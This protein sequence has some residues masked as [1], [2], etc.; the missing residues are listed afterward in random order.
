LS[1]CTLPKRLE[2]ESILAYTI[3][4]S[5]ICAKIK[6]LEKRKQRAQFFTPLKVSKFMGDMFTIDKT[7][8]KL[9]DAGA[10]VGNLSAAF[11]QRLLDSREKY[12]IKID[13]YENDQEL[14]P[15]LANNLKVCIQ[16]LNDNGHQASYNILAHD[17]VEKNQAFLDSNMV[18]QPSLDIGYD[19][20]ISNPPYY[21]LN[22]ESIQAEIMRNHKLG[23]PNIYALFMILAAR[24]LKQNGELVF[25]TPRSFCSGLYFNKFRKIFLETVRIDHIH[26]FQSRRDIFRDDDV[27]QENILLRATKSNVAL[28]TVKISSSK[29]KQFSDYGEIVAAKT[30]V[31]FKK[32]GDVFIRIP[33]SQCD[34][35]IQRL[36][37]AFPNVLHD[38]GLEVSTGPVVIFRT[39]ETVNSQ[40]DSECTTVPLLWAHNLNNMLIDLSRE[41]KGK[42]K[43][44]KVNE[45]SRSILVQRKNYILTKRFSSKE[46]QKRLQTAVFAKDSFPHKFVAFENHLNFIHQLKGEMPDEVMWGLAA[47]LSSNIVDNFFKSL[48][49]STQVNAVEIRSLPL[50]SMEQIKEIGTKIMQ[51]KPVTDYLI[52]NIVLST[53]NIRIL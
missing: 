39:K 50:P 3:R 20:I 22:G 19:F 51:A 8:I 47:L 2:S 33:A 48:S 6:G 25:I 42:A 15:A 26:L 1:S 43:F 10:G 53:L 21:K 7:E 11:C 29:T 38:L 24:L 44:I 31:I 23:H 45:E 30:D 27:L 5:E 32:N 4:I 34:L 46:E 35:D 12:S 16:E 18:K 13:A 37:D 41:R 40:S 36:V 9:L 28:E 17:F 14:I 49:G 52:D